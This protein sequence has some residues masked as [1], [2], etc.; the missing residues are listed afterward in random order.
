M[1]PLKTRDIKASLIKKGFIKEEG[2]HHYY[3]YIH[4]GKKTPIR[5]KL[6]HGKK[7]I[8]I[9]LIGLMATQTKL[10]NA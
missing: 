5:T 4:N 9:G 8:G 7:E 6:S 3:Y 10:N 2:D 1:T